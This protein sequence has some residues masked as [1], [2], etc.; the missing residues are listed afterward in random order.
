MKRRDTKIKFI[1]ESAIPQKNFYI[2]NAHSNIRKLVSLFPVP[3]SSVVVR[4]FRNRASFSRAIHK[5]KA[6]D[7]LVAYVPPKSISHICVFDD[8]ERFTSK[9]ILSQ[10]LLHE[11]THL[12]TNAL[13]PNLPDWLK[14]GISVYVASQIFKP[15]ISTA[16]WKKIV[17]K[18]IPFKR[19]SWRFT[20]EHNGYNIAGLLIMFFVRR[21]GWEKF[22]TAISYR[23]PTRFSI[24]NIPLYFNDKFEWFIADFKKQFVR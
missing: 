7:W 2:R 16:D 24:T 6:P 5:K 3:L 14:E 9:K 12:Y 21:Y 4:I 19:V 18:D 10:V 15:S 22:I 11:M 20:T 23:Y 1:F 13:N 17:K 8:K